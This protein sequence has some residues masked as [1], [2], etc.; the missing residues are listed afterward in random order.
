MDLTRIFAHTVHQ[1][2][3]SIGERRSRFKGSIRKPCDP[4]KSIHPF[5]TPAVV[6]LCV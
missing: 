3:S 1:A 4:K 5:R 2:N 6:R